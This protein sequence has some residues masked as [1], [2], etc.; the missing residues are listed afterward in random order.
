MKM[1]TTGL[2]VGHSAGVEKHGFDARSA[3]LE[4]TPGRVM[5]V[6]IMW[7]FVWYEPDWLVEKLG[8]GVYL[9]KL[10]ALMFIPVCI[11]LMK[12]LRREAVFWPYLLIIGIFLVWI[13]FVLNPAYLLN[14]VTKILQYILLTALTVSVL[15]TPKQLAPL[16]KL[17]FFGFIWFGVQGI[18]AGRVWWHQ[19]LG[20]E[21]SFGPFMTIALGFSYYVAMGTTL[22]KYRYLALATCLLGMA[23]TIVSFARGAFIGLC[24]VLAVLAFRTPRKL[25]FLGYGALL[26]V[27]GQIVIM[28]MF[29]HGEFWDEMATITGE[30]TSAGT[31]Q[32]R[33]V[34]W[35]AAWEVFLTSPLVGVGPNNFG[36]NAVEYFTSRGVTNMGGGIHDPSLLYQLSLHNDYVQV[37]VEMGLVGLFALAAVFA[38]FFRCIGFLRTKAVQ[39]AWTSQPGA[40]IDSNNLALGLEAAMIGVLVSSVFYPQFFINYWFWSIMM[41]ALA[42]TVISRNL[43]KTRTATQSAALRR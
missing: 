33:W 9:L 39:E 19:N 31:G 24:V 27:A 32:H 18:L 38:Y 29:P 4:R 34:L 40:F 8:G 15:E 41:L 22:K 10:Y 17:F 16:L 14:G 26:L 28:V 37:M 11:L 7:A 3:P 13:P 2:D 23:G 35:Q 20:N 36:P 42:A 30:G 25:A 5:F 21:D 43:V 12:H 1:T 6:C